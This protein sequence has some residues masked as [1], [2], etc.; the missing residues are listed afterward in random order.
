MRKIINVFDNK[1]LCRAIWTF[2]KSEGW[3]TDLNFTLGNIERNTMNSLEI[4]FA[5]P[6]E[7]IGWWS[8]RIVSDA[9]SIKSFA[10]FMLLYEDI[11]KNKEIPI[12]L[13]GDFT[14]MVTKDGVQVGCQIFSHKVVLDVAAA[15]KKITKT[16]K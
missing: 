14:A 3:D 1:P 4:Y 13:N 5:I 9:P 2:L 15:I 7:T 16:N 10:D 8:G 12:K 6:K 11:G